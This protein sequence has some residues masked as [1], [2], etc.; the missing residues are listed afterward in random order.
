[1]A[2]IMKSERGWKDGNTFFPDR[3][4]AKDGSVV[5]DERIIPFLVGKRQCPGSTSLPYFSNFYFPLPFNDDNNHRGYQ[6]Q[7]QNLIKNFQKY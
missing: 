3:H 4:L 7:L 5:H 1:M 6:N 2:G